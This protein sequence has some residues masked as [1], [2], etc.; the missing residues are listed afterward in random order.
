M[1]WSGSVLFFFSFF[2]PLVVFVLFFNVS[3]CFFRGEKGLQ[4]WFSG[5]LEGFEVCL[6]KFSGFYTAFEG[7]QDFVGILVGKNCSRAGFQGF[8]G[9]GGDFSREKVL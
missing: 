3:S 5:F 2:F 8:L 9:R 7:F 4:G 1:L 6:V